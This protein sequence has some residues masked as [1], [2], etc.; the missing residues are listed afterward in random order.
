[1]TLCPDNPTPK[2]G[3]ALRNQVEERL[4]FF[5]TGEPPT[6]NAEAL[7]KV[8]A[9]VGMDI[10]EDDEDD[11]EN[12]DMDVDGASS[13]FLP[14]CL[15]TSANLPPQAPPS[16][17]SRRRHRRRNPRRR[18]SARRTTWTSTRTTSPRRRR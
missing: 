1:M 8:L 17:R 6:K 16:P 13:A 18:T 7:R 9:E 15:I 14:P 4:N 5:A 12:G 10:D 11:K 3:E 2:F